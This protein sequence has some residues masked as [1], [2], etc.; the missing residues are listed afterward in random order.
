[1]SASR[2]EF[3][4]KTKLAAFAR[5]GGRCE[6]G[7]GKKLM[8]GDVEY[9]HITAAALGGDNSLENCR[10]LSRA[11]HRAKTNGDVAAIAKSNRN[12]AKHI[13]AHKS[14]HPMRCGRHS[15][16][17]KKLDGTVVLRETGEPVGGA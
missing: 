8:P 7:C 5:A 14:K 1:M 4:K 9:D 2:Q 3:T 13:G 16:F 17:K 6:C 11:C 12:R 10:V 15:K